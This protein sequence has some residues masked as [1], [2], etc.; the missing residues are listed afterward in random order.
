MT[1]RYTIIQHLLDIQDEGV[2]DINTLNS[3]TVEQLTELL[4]YITDIPKDLE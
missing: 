1:D 2:F 3:M 4:A